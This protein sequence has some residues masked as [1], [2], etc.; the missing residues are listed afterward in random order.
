MVCGYIANKLGWRDR[1]PWIRAV[2]DGG[3]N[4]DDLLPDFGAIRS[5]KIP[6]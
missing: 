4:S 3:L 1:S 5:E 2:L 6:G